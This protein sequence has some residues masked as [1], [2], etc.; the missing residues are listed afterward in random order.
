MI[1]CLEQKDKGEKIHNIAG[2][3]QNAVA[4]GLAEM[5]INS[6]EDVEVPVIQGCGEVFYGETRSVAV[7]DKVESAGYTFVQHKNSCAGDGLI[8]IGHK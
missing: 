8:S 4:Y 2:A 6:A 7:R 5:A 3:A 1:S